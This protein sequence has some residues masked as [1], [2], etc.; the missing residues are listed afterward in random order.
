MSSRAAA[1]ARACDTLAALYII[2]ELKDMGVQP[3]GDDVA[4]IWLPILWHGGYL[5]PFL[6]GESAR[7]VPESTG[8]TSNIVGF[9]AGSDPSIDEIVVVGAH[10]DHVG[11]EGGASTTAPMTTRRGPP[12][13]SRSRARSRAP[14]RR[15]DGACW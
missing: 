10:Y 1:R 9:I 11:K 12:A 15:L 7:S 3:R 14:R 4:A 6:L 5:Q 8:K 13:R 2:S